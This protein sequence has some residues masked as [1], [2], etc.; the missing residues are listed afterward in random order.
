MPTD[1]CSLCQYDLDSRTVLKCGHVICI[2]CF[3]KCILRTISSEPDEIVQCPHCEVDLLEI[4]IDLRM[5]HYEMDFE[6]ERSPVEISSRKEEIQEI[7]CISY[8]RE[9]KIFVSVRSNIL[10]RFDDVSGKGEA[11]CVGKVNGDAINELSEDD[12]KWA[13]EHGM[14]LGPYEPFHQKDS[15]I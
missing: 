1:I 11:V 3:A 2:K 12:K 13:F 8:N 10:F 14:T 9:Q 6:V 15:K 7:D 5:E 4:H